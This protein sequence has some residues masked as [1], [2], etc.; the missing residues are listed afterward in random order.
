MI[1]VF[2]FFVKH[3]L[4]TVWLYIGVFFFIK[5][6]IFQWKNIW[7]C[8]EVWL[9]KYLNNTHIMYFNQTEVISPFWLLY[10]TD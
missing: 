10:D 8:T 1:Q 6:V 9:F 4:Q 5:V 2:H 7:V 3:I